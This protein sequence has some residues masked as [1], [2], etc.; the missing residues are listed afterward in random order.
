MPTEN[1]TLKVPSNLLRLLEEKSFFGKTKE[2]WF[3]ECIRQGVD[4]ELNKLKDQRE[5]RR[6]EKKYGL[7]V[8]E[9]AD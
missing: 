2:A 6:L 5:I 7:E 1:V 3:A 8:P 9:F 4:V